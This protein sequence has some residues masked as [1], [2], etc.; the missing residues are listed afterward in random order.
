MTFLEKIRGYKK[1]TAAVI[2]L[3]VALLAELVGLPEVSIDWIVQILSTYLI[4][5]GISDAGSYYGKS[6]PKQYDE[7]AAKRIEVKKAD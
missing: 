6:L 7:Y 4:G 3:I 5:Q 2:G 1:I